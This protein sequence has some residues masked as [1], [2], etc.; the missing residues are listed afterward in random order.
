[1]ETNLVKFGGREVEV[2]SEFTHLALDIDGKWS[3]FKDKPRF[4]KSRG[5]WKGQGQQEFGVSSFDHDYLEKEWSVHTAAN[6]KHFLLGFCG[7]CV[8][9]LDPET[10]LDL[11]FQIKERW[12]IFKDWQANRDLFESQDPLE[13]HT[14]SFQE[15]DEVEIPAKFTHIAVD[16]NGDICVFKKEPTLKTTGEYATWS[17]SGRKQIGV[18]V[19]DFAKLEGKP[20]DFENAKKVIAED[21][22]DF[23]FMIEDVLDFGDVLNQTGKFKIVFAKYNEIDKLS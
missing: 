4:I 15:G 17:G 19:W 3:I 8:Q 1:M 2:S 6:T 13:A 20:K 10:V 9:E 21:L 7:R 16:A 18:A 5:A 22:E 23:R 11:D 12:K 14:M